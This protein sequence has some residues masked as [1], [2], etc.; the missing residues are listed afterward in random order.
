MKNYCTLSDS[1]YLKF[2]KALFK[3]LDA[4]CDENFILHYLCIDDETY[5]ELI[6]YDSRLIPVKLD[7]VLSKYP[8]LVKYKETKAYNEFC[9]SLAS[10]FSLYLLEHNK[11]ESIFYIDS[12]IFF[13]QDPKLIFDEIADKSVGIIRHR[14]NTSISVDGEFNVGVIYFKNDESGLGCLRWWNNAILLGTN[15]E[16]GTCGDQKYLEGFIPRF[17]DSVCV[18]DETIAH[19]APWNFRL[20]VY[21]Y[22]QEDGTV[23]W[24]DKRQP[25]VFNHFSKFGYA[26]DGRIFPD[27]GAYGV[28]TMGGA[29]Y[30]IPAVSAMYFDYDKVLKNV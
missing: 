29:V 3:S 27:R 17:G 8:N 6:D 4:Q 10:S 18:I 13:Y 15:P 22:L 5:E 9:W 28:H 24:G 12:D 20:Y 11:I 30:T 25:L 19:G 2:G 23:V 1:T 26:D 14:H 21:D 7:E 16:L